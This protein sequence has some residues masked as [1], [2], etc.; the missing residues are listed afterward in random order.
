[1]ARAFCVWKK[2]TAYGNG[3]QRTGCILLAK[4]RWIFLEA[5]TEAIGVE[6]E[7]VR[8]YT[9]STSLVEMGE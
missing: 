2:V 6:A 8:K 3:Y 9:A 4:F 7:V 5:E 1:M